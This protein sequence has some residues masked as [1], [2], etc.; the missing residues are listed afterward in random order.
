VD[1]K[2][3]L[4]AG[5]LSDA[6]DELNREVKADPVDI[7]R[8]TTLF[9][10]LC[11]AGDYTRAE[12]QLDIIAQQDA[13]VDIG[14]QIYRNALNAERLRSRLRSDGLQ[15][16]FILDPPPFAALHLEAFNRLREGRAGEARALLERAADTEDAVGGE[17]NG[18][19][20]AE[21]SDG[22]ALLSPFIELIIQD[23][24]VWLPFVQVKR[25]TVAAPKKLRDLIWIPAEL[26]SIDGP[27]GG[28]FIPV[29]Y[30]GSSSHADEQVRLGRATDWKDAGAGLMRGFGQRILF[31]DDN[32]RSI[33]Q[34]GHVEVRSGEE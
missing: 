6:L 25:L 2:E 24:Y 1:A 12:R 16:S 19:P 15:P 21:I 13:N 3:L 8:R 27:I 10:L 34:L 9:E 26:E 31:I 20:F 28:A 32:E 22:D 33:L 18:E 7:R 4:S 30:C 5:R 11:F 17:V 29:L 14:A 23:R